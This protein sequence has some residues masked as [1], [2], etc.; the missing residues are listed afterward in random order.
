MPR[1]ILHSSRTFSSVHVL[2]KQQASVLGCTGYMG[3]PWNSW[4]FIIVNL[5]QAFVERTQFLQGC[6][7]RDFCR[8][9]AQNLK[10]PRRGLIVNRKPCCG[11][12]AALRLGATIASIAQTL[13]LGQF[14]VLS[15]CPNCK[16]TWSKR[17]SKT[18]SQAPFVLHFSRG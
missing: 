4:I 11:L 9:W 17:K 10:E 8:A 7:C 5:C 2:P 14:G 15:F 16:T 3:K 1:N 12:Q 13:A 6:N 18:S